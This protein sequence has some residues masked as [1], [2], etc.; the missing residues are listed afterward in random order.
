VNSRHVSVKSFYSLQNSFDELD[1]HTHA[2]V[3]FILQLRIERCYSSTNI[4]NIR[5]VSVKATAIR[6]TDDVKLSTPS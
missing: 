4:W 6:N 3:H 5:L 1:S 2:F